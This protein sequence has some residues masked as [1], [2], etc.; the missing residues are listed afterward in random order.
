MADT[1]STHTRATGTVARLVG[2]EFTVIMEAIDNDQESPD[3]LA[4]KLNVAVAT[5]ETVGFKPVTLSLSSCVAIR[6]HH[7]SLCA[8]ELISLSDGAM[9][10]EKGRPRRRTPH[11]PEHHR[12]ALIAMSY[13]DAPRVY[14]AVERTVLAWQRT[15]ITQ[16]LAAWFVAGG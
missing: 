6:E 2:D 15:A 4:Q 16:G 11:R 13:L 10:T 5:I 9:Y 3:R 12:T 7:S 1:L 14:F 8:D